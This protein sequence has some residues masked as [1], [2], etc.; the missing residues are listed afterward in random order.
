M[1][2]IKVDEASATQGSKGFSDAASA[3]DKGADIIEGVGESI[4]SALKGSAGSALQTTL[5][6]SFGS[7][8]NCAVNGNQLAQLILAAKQTFSEAD[9]NAANAM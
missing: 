8:V 5:Q 9:N 2:E 4:E 7:Y 3:F 6:Y 1:P